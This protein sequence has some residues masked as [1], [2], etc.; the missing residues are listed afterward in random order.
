MPGF[1]I[2]RGLGPGST[3]TSFILQGFGPI[4]K[5]VTRIIR[6]GRSELSRLYKDLVETIKISAKLASVNGKLI[7]IPIFNNI[8]RDFLEETIIKINVEPTK[9]T[10]RE[11][12]DLKVTASHIINKRKLLK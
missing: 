2:T 7:P 12:D 5:E 3:P 4:A 6:G 9:I 10:K 8:S 1:T 11:V